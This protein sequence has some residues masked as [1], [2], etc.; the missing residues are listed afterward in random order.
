MMLALL[1]T[2][3][4]LSKSCYQLLQLVQDYLVQDSYTCVIGAAW[5]MVEGCMGDIDGL[6]SGLAA[7]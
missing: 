1:S 2:N 3:L 4:R 7:C 5:H 6:M